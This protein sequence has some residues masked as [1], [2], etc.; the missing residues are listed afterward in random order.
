MRF[1]NIEKRWIL[2]RA[3]HEQETVQKQLAQRLG[4]AEAK[5]NEQQRVNQDYNKYRKVAAVTSIAAVISL[6]FAAAS[7]YIAESS[8]DEFEEQNLII[9]RQT[10]LI[11]SSRRSELVFELSSLFD[12]IDEELDA[13]END[14]KERSTQVPDTLSSRL[15]GRIIAL[16]RSLQPYYFWD[17]SSLTERA[18]S[19]ER[20][21][22]L[23]SLT[24]SGIDTTSMKMILTDGDFSKALLRDANLYRTNMRF[25]LL[26]GAD[27]QD[28]YLNYA[29][30]SDAVLSEATLR[31]AAL[32]WSKLTFTHLYKTDLSRAFLSNAD[33]RDALLVEA[34]LQGTILRNADLSYADLQ[35][36]DLSHANLINANLFQTKLEGANLSG[37]IFHGS[38]L[39]SDE[40]LSARNLTWESLCAAASL[41]GA[42][43]S[44]AL[45]DSVSL[46]CPSKFGTPDSFRVARERL[47]NMETSV[48][49]TQGLTVP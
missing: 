40:P 22:L 41:Q 45:L 1:S 2:Q 11:E 46:H 25:I 27:L 32:S 43:L 34:N 20:G 3:L 29:N 5:L 38:T 36:A 19:P 24:L 6:L 28:A 42:H 14:E 8:L 26:R 21:Q 35:D 48:L 37:A 23:I 33:I 9:Q 13:I 49:Q 30:F 39:M 15:I 12:E 16:S 17:D 4:A 44:P 7:V 31:N 47:A 10:H 18:L